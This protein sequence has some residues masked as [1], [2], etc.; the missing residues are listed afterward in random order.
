MTR[1]SDMPEYRSWSQ[2]K[3]RCNNPNFVKWKDYG[4]RG[5]KYSRSWEKF[6][7]FLRD[8]GPKPQGTY[9]DRLDYDGD[10]RKENCRWATRTQQ[11]HNRR[12]NRMLTYR[13]ETLPLGAMARKYGIPK[14]TLRNRVIDFGWDVP[15]AIEMAPY[16]N[17]RGIGEAGPS[18]ARYYVFRLSGLTAYDIRRMKSENPLDPESFLE[19]IGVPLRKNGAGV[20]LDYLEVHG[21]MEEAER[22]RDEIDPTASERRRELERQAYRRI[23]DMAEELSDR[24]DDMDRRLREIPDLTLEE[25]AERL[26]AK[27][28]T[29]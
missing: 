25:A 5:I 17:R 20:E 27:G 23:A 3:H 12:D 7:N 16:G 6:D 8:M 2:M 29:K 15:R 21:S 9:L 4:G 11:Q 24:I 19:R 10:Y 28:E 22:A 13:G 14:S 1:K 26:R 18:V